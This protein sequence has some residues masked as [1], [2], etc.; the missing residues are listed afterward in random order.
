MTL[1]VARS[2]KGARIAMPVTVPDA[3]EKIAEENGATI[4]RTRSDQR[5]VMANADGER[6]TLDFAGGGGHEPIFPQFQPVFDALFAATKLMEMVA[7]ERRKLSELVDELPQWHMARRVIACPWE[8][9]GE[10]M[11]TLLDEQKHNK[12][13]LIDGIR[14]A[15]DGGW[16][17]VLP[18]AS[19]PTLNIYAEG[20]TDHD[21]SRYID[22]V[23]HRIGELVG[24]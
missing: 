8:R 20:R 9:K 22:E 12:V 10:V 19:D 16:V 2:K 1:C 24:R 14:V 3:I 4:V 5:S 23:S 6:A 7:A 21:A 18:D 11:R 15:R 17:L 13:E